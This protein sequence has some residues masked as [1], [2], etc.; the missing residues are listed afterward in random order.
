ML[1]LLRLKDFV[2]SAIAGHRVILMSAQGEDE[3]WAF[4]KK[5]HESCP[6]RVT[7]EEENYDG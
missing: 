3:R 6:T 2:G 1:P 4:L 7:Q 5:V